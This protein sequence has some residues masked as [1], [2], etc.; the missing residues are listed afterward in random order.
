MRNP[1]EWDRAYA[2]AGLA[3]DVDP[4]PEL[5]KAV[6]DLPPGRAVEFGCGEGR[7]AIWLATRGWRVTAV[8]FSPVAVDRGRQVADRHGVE[9]D[10]QVA[11]VRAYEPAGP[12]DLAVV[13]YLHIGSAEIATVLRRAAAALA[14]GGILFVLGWDRSNAVAGTGGPR[15]ADLLYDAAEMTRAVAG[16]R[17]RR[18]EAVPQLGSADAADLVL[19]AYRPPA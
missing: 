10:W 6:G 11:D 13:L 3:F 4:H 19:T 17:V 2:A 1:D 9:V 8:D 18:A 7:P 15:P 16:L 14:P 12:I 5:A